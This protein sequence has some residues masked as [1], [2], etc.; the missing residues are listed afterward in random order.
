M[1]LSTENSHTPWW[2]YS[3]NL[4]QGLCEIQME[5][6]N[7]MEPVKALSLP[8]IRLKKKDGVSPINPS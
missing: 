8:S 7:V 2:R 1:S 4:P 6:P 5:Q 3:V